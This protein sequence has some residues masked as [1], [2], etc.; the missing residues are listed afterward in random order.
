MGASP[1][2]HQNCDTCLVERVSWW[3]AVAYANILSAEEGLRA[4]YEL[5]DCKGA[6]GAGCPRASD[7]YC[8]GDRT[9]SSIERVVHCTGYRLPTEAEWERAARAGDIQARY[10][11]PDAIGWYG[12]NSRA[13]THIVGD[14]AAN[15]WGLRDM[16]GNVE[17]WC[18]DWEVGPTPIS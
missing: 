3:D 7:S 17:E 9:C 1:S 14:R 18:E 5:S 6:P 10:G 16:L 13:E 15:A 4:C 2:Y 12:Q 8:Y 11:D